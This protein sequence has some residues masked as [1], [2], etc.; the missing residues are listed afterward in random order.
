[1]GTRHM[2][3]INEN[4][5]SNE[6]PADGKGR[7]VS[8]LGN[9]VWG[10]GAQ[11]ARRITVR[12]SAGARGA[13]PSVLDGAPG[14]LSSRRDSTQHRAHGLRSSGLAHSTGTRASVAPAPGPGLLAAAPRRACRVRPSCPVG[15]GHRRGETWKPGRRL[16]LPHPCKPGPGW[17]GWGPQMRPMGHSPNTHTC[18]CTH[19]HT[20]TQTQACTEAH[21]HGHAC[22]D[23]H[24]FTDSCNELQPGQ[25]Q[26]RRES[27][28]TDGQTD[29]V[30]CV[31]PCARKGRGGRGLPPSCTLLPLR[32]QSRAQGTLTAVFPQVA[33]RHTVFP[34][35]SGPGAG[36][37]SARPPGGSGH[38][39]AAGIRVP[40][41]SVPH[42]HD[43]PVTARLPRG[44][45]T[46]RAGAAAPPR[47]SE[48]RLAAPSVHHRT[49]RLDA[50]TVRSG[51]EWCNVATHKDLLGIRK[52]YVLV[53][54][55][56][57]STG[58]PRANFSAM[59]TV[60]LKLPA[61]TCCLRLVRTGPRVRDMQR[62][63]GPLR[64]RV[65]HPAGWAL[66]CVLPS[67]GCFSHFPVGRG[68]PRLRQAGSPPRD[69]GRSPT[70]AS[71]TGQ[72]GG[73]P[74]RTPWA[75]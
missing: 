49:A 8:G 60:K 42:G 56:C 54:T 29:R 75:S 74:S 71:P 1:M 28:V 2:R 36:R 32:L 63:K 10:C 47:S 65:R 67:K 59:P 62:S 26:G 34:T 7:P 38:S 51:R 55:C 69:G 11:G 50:R 70:R 68:V 66:T 3:I 18:M 9:G 17:E 33:L 44:A 19:T 6:L 45:L 35:S 64:A 53:S 40:S 72:P 24:T 41:V 5:H 15:G 23:T 12:T 57:T 4:V 21:T 43:D 37:P 31:E 58:C 39:S 61:G 16:P 27:W 13:S 48:K 52:R 14:K 22:T 25:A 30:R 20:H 73:H 46:Q